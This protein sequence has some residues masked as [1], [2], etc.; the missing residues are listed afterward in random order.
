M[1]PAIPSTFGRLSD[2]FISSLGAVTGSENRLNFRDSKRVIAILVDGLGSQNLKAAAGH[3]P[4]LNQAMAG[5]KNISCGFPS[6]TASS[7]ASF[8]TGDSAGTHGLVGYKVFD[9]KT[10]T[11]F[12][13]LNGWDAEHRPLDW[14][15]SQTVT[16]RALASGVGAYSIGPKAYEGSDFTQATMTGAKYLAGKTI[17]DRFD[18]AREL[19]RTERSDFIA[20]L[21]IPELDQ[22]GHAQGVSSDKWL[23]SLEEVDSQV[24]T[25]SAALGKTDSLLLTA[26]HGVIDIPAHAHVYLD[27][28][29]TEWSSVV[30]VSG[31]PRVNF[32]Y[33]GNPSVQQAMQKELQDF[34]G[35]RGLVLSKSDVVAAGW[36]G[37]LRPDVSLKL[38]DLFVLATKNV[39]FYHRGYAPAASL[40]MV[41]QHGALSSVEMSIPLLGWGGFRA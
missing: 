30:D 1:L 4:F 24:R 3:A 15:H 19:L 41:G 9:R 14:Q 38:P 27:E 26:D 20:Y 17:A 6:T 25:L 29:K 39:A 37:K 40:N 7:I 36:Y 18:V 32:I 34:I 16:E 28:A 23:A 35:D 22:I 11:A 5:R 8:A 31:D 13:L 10:H 21:Y 33:L 2:V 12:N